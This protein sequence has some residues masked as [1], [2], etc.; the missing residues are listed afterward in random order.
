MTWRNGYRAPENWPL[1]LALLEHYFLLP[2]EHWI[3][4]VWESSGIA[5]DP[6]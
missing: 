4:V 5:R 6:A 3:A 1:T 2:A